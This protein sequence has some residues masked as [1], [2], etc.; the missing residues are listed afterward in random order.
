MER[1][2]AIYVC[3]RPVWTFLLFVNLVWWEYRRK[4]PLWRTSKRKLWVQMRPIRL[5][6]V[7]VISRVCNN[8]SWRIKES[9]LCWSVAELQRSFGLLGMIGFS[10]SIVT[11]Y[12]VLIQNDKFSRWYKSQLE[13]SWWC[14]G[15]GSQ[16]WWSSCDD[17][18]MAWNQLCV[19]V[20]C[21]FN[22]RNVFRIPSCWGWVS[23]SLQTMP[24]VINWRRLN[25]GQYSWVYILSPKIIRRQ[26]SYL[27][28][29]FMIIGMWM[30]T[31]SRW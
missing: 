17:L 5:W 22:G 7:W 9:A 23:C 2:I 14:L 25:P 31:M 11:W 12:V 19:F 30:E 8:R 10:F 3:V 27:T 6:R 4:N 16:C 26:F 21:I 24:W 15:D 29:W 1:G 20:C 28:G 18:G 13:C